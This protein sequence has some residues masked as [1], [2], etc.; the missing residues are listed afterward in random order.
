MNDVKRWYTSK[1]TAFGKVSKNKSGQSPASYTPRQKWVY[2]RMSFI[3]CH[4]RRKGESRTAGVD[5][6]T[7][8]VHNDSTRS[9]TDVESLDT[10]GRQGLPMTS[11]PLS[12][13]LAT[14][15]KLLEHFEAMRT[16][17]SKFVEKPVDKRTLFFDFVASEASKLSQEQ[18]HTL[19]GKV[20]N[21]LQNVTA[22]NLKPATPSPAPTPAPTPAPP[23]T[24]RQPTPLSRRTATIL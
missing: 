3:C 10:S 1:R 9:S 5:A 2:D 7:S 18:Y 22:S 4:I 23:P 19:K 21:A 16:M 11:M 24:Q 17:V 14:E 20:F 6:S 15:P 12:T 13:G 8:K